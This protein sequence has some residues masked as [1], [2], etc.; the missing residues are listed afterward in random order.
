[1]YYRTCCLL[2]FDQLLI[3]NRCLI[4]L[5]HSVRNGRACKIVTSLICL[6]SQG[7][8]LRLI[9]ICLTEHA[10]RVTVSFVPLAR[11]HETN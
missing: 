9:L 8:N 7:I 1:M 2:I 5:N 4:C 3:A 11:N 10:D 6:E